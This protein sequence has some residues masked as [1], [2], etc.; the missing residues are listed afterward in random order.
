MK[1]IELEEAFMK[2]IELE[3]AV[4]IIYISYLLYLLTE[5]GSKRNL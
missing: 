2:Y 1:Y 4:I 3:E 5:E